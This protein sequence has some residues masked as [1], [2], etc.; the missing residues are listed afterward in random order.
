[1]N[2]KHKWQF[3]GINLGGNHHGM[4]H[5]MCRC[6]AELY[7]WPTKAEIRR[8]DPEGE[9]QRPLPYPRKTQDGVNKAV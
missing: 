7:Q 8:H 2:H 9:T 6:G 1:M 4:S 3:R 5:R